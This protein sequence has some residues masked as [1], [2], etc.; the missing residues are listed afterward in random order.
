MMGARNEPFHFGI[1]DL[2][3][4]GRNLVKSLSYFKELL[5]PSVSTLSK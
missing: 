2:E 3:N 1:E 5:V 4:M